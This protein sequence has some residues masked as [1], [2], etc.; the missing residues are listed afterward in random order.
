MP[1]HTD[2]AHRD[3]YHYDAWLPSTPTACMRLFILPLPVSSDSGLPLVPAG[4]PVPPTACDLIPCPLRILQ[5]RT[6][7]IVGPAV[8]PARQ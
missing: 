3:Q 1:P 4:P 7:L 2:D 6:L 5:I 8:R